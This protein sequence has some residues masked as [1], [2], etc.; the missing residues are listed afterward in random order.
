MSG[1]RYGDGVVPEQ[2][3]G[4][5][6]PG[7]DE[8]RGDMDDDRHGEPQ[9]AQALGHVHAAGGRVSACGRQ[10]GEGFHDGLR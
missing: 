9:Q 10:A 2:V 4:R 8:Q 5:V 7:D 6:V 3:D 1:V